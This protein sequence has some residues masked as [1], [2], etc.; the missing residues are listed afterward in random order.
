M[1]KNNRTIQ[2]SDG[3]WSYVVNVNGSAVDMSD[4]SV[5]DNELDALEA[6]GETLAEVRTTKLMRRNHSLD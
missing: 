6:L 3:R 2:L 4:G 5:F 1:N